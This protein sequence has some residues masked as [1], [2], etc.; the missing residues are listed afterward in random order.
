MKY[1][2]KSAAMVMRADLLNALDREC[3]MLGSR[4]RNAKAEAEASEREYHAAIDRRERIKEW[5]KENG[6]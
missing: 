1:P 2:P 5:I 4:V 6:L 3:V